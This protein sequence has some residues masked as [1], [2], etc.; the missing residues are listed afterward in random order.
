MARLPAMSVAVVGVQFPSKRK[1]DPSRRFA[2]GL[3][4]PG[5][6]VTLRREPDNPADPRAIAV[7]NDRG[8]Q[9]GYLPAERSARLSAMLDRGR[10][11]AAVFQAETTAGAIIRIAFDGELPS[12]DGLPQP[13]VPQAEPDWYADEIYPDD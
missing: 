5:D 4:A 7:F 10:V 9:M 11:I 12:I 2:V 3:C 6:P 1:K 8:M 13:A